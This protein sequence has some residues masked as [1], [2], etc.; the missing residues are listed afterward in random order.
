MNKQKIDM[1]NFLTTKITA[2]FL[3]TLICV[4]CAIPKRCG[5][6]ELVL[7]SD[8]TVYAKLL[9]DSITEIVL[10]S[11]LVVC[12]LLS[13][14]PI[15]SIRTDSIRILPENMNTVIKYLFFD[16]SN[17]CSNDIVYGRFSSS[18]RYTFKTRH[19]QTL[20]LDLDF[21]LKKWKLLDSNGN[22]ICIS[23]MKKS[24]LYFLRFTRI[25][26][27]NDVTLNLLYNNLIF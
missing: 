20:Y 12:Q 11:N 27:P 21:G 25:I 7:K 8:T 6:N 2:L 19:G 1:K 4:S 5:S 26:F 13:L 22:E 14:N 10:N 16:P 9:N 24:N 17:F 23:D 3:T 18:A 15:D